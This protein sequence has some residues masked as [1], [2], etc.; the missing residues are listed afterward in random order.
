M[1]IYTIC[2][3]DR[4]GAGF[5]SFWRPWAGVV[6]FYRVTNLEDP[7]AEIKPQEPMVCTVCGGALEVSLP[8]AVR[9]QDGDWLALDLKQ[10]ERALAN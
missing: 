3:C 1:V 7:V 10:V 2:T 5:A 9:S 4:C 8:Y 6:L